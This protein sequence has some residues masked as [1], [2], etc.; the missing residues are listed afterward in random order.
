MSCANHRRGEAIVGGVQDMAKHDAI[1][2]HI[3]KSRHYNIISVST[4]I[5]KMVNVD[6]HGYKMKRSMPKQDV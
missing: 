6:N 3:H 4:T 1:T 5:N 2:H